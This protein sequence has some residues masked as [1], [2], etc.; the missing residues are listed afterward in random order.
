M[1]YWPFVVPPGK[2]LLGRW[3]Y[4]AEDPTN[5]AEQIASLPEHLLFN[6]DPSMI[7]RAIKK[8][9]NWWNEYYSAEEA[10]Y[11]LKAGEIM[12][13]KLKNIGVWTLENEDGRNI[14]FYCGESESGA[15]VGI[16]AVRHGFEFD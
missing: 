5:K 10:N 4:E 9:K 2:Y 7:E 15:T 12:K 8:K 16:L 3:K 6:L 13:S 11:R 1:P 14:I